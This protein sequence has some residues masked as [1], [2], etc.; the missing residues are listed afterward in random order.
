MHVLSMAVRNLHRWAP[1]PAGA[2][3]G[4]ARRARRGLAPGM[5]DAA[6]LR[7]VLFTG[8]GS[9]GHSATKRACWSLHGAQGHGG[10]RACQS[11]PEHSE[12]A[13]LFIQLAHHCSRHS[14]GREL[15]AASRTRSPD[16]WGRPPAHR[17]APCDQPSAAA[18]PAGSPTRPPGGPV[19][20][21]CTSAGNWVAARWHAAVAGAAGADWRRTDPEGAVLLPLPAAAAAAPLPQYRRSPS[22]APGGGRQLW[23]ARRHL[24]RSCGSC[25][26]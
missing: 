2:C 14:T 10:A 15:R 4:H 1:C 7:A 23:L 8:S 11:A 16:T 12:Q 5:A 25:P 21:A 26:T 19:S 6:F 13:L 3:T 24:R 9:S 22:S 17:L 18:S 20:P